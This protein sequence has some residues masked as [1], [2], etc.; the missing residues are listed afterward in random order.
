VAAVLA[1]F[2]QLQLIM[3]PPGALSA[4]AAAAAAAASSGKG[5]AADGSRDVAGERDGAVGLRQE[6]LGASGQQAGS[7]GQPGLERSTAELGAQLSSV[8]GPAMQARG[9]PALV[10]AGW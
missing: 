7:L 4:A 8:A 10:D 1:A 6:G 5:P 3:Q 2:P 9:A